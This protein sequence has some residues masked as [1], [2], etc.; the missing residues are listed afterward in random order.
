LIWSDVWNVTGTQTTHSD[1]HMT[2]NQLCSGSLTLASVLAALL[3][4]SSGPITGG[5]AS[6]EASS[7]GNPNAAATGGALQTGGSATGGIVV[8]LNDDLDPETASGGSADDPKMPTI[9]DGGT[10]VLTPE[11]VAKIEMAECTGSSAVAKKIPTVLQLVIDTSESMDIE[12]PGAALGETRWDVASQ[13]VVEAVAALPDEMAVGM[14]FFPTSAS[15]MGGR[16]M[17]MTDPPAPWICVD[18][19]GQTP[20]DFLGAAGSLHRTAIDQA[21]FDAE[22]FLGTPTHDG[23]TFALNESLLT[24]T[25]EGQKSMLLITDG[26]PA[27]EL[28]CGALL[29]NGAPTEPIIAE[30]AAAYEKGIRTYIIGA[31][32]SESS[33]TGN[34]MRGWLSAAAVAGGTPAEGC[35]VEGPNFCHFDMT[36]APDFAVALAEGLAAISQ[37]VADLCTFEMPAPPEGETSTDPNLTSV[38]IEWSNGTSEL[39][40]RDEVADCQEGWAVDAAGKIAL[41][42]ATCAR[43]KQDGSVQARVSMGCDPDEV[44]FH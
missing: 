17:G 27:N 28:G 38:I 42:A 2:S 4:C 39:I 33:R 15:P 5:T 9:R 11:E 1:G 40:L 10:V 37:D 44:I 29:Q 43:V 18:E 12:A 21:I 14:Q 34:D 16:G 31:P 6:P 26:E 36:Q 32:G 35:T 25:I 20:I 13:A 22:L 41:C 3:G 19:S 24:T 7:G 8:D 23:Y 30:I